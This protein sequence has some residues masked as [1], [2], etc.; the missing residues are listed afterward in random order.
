MK[1]ERLPLVALVGRPN[2]GKSSLFN[3]LT[4]KRNAIVD[5]TPGVT[6][7]RHYAKVTWQEQTFIL[8]DTGGIEPLPTRKGDG[9]QAFPKE[10]G[11]DDRVKVV[12]GIQEQTW[13]AIKEADVILC[14]LDGRAGVA[15]EDYRVADILR[16]SGKPV[17]F[18]VNKIDTH[19]LEDQLVGQ[20]YELGLETLWPIS[21]AHGYGLNTFM[22]SLVE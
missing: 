20:F 18:L 11:T 9:G 3:R 14:L 16:K 1:T 4:R 22:E 13:Q 15:G 8:I 17:F 2:V 6:R 21:A 7:D 19:Q 10:V 12:G 5:A